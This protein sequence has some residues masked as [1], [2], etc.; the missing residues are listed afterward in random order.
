MDG[1]LQRNI[2]NCK[3]RRVVPLVGLR[4]RAVKHLLNT[5]DID[6]LIN[7][8]ICGLQHGA[9]TIWNA[10]LIC[11]SP[12]TRVAGGLRT[13]AEGCSSSSMLTCIEDEGRQAGD[14]AVQTGVWVDSS[15]SNVKLWQRRSCG[16]SFGREERGVSAWPTGQSIEQ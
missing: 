8:K 12:S 14:N 13:L 3:I 10:S 4:R 11:C 5:I 15:D 16:D 7:H 2:M 6:I 9:S 1:R